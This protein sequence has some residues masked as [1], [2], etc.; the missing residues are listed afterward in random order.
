M[1]H[2]IKL[3]VLTW[4]ILLISTYSIAQKRN[5][6]Y[7]KDDGKEV[8][9]KDSADFMRIIQEPDSS[10]QYFRVLEFYPDNSRKL[11]GQVSAFEP[12]LVFEGS[13]MSFY[14]NGK[15]ASHITYIMGSPFGM[16]YH[17]YPDGKVKKAL[18]YTSIAMEPMLNVYQKDRYEVLDYFDSAGVQLVKNGNGY[19]VFNE[20]DTSREEGSYRNG[21]KDSVWKGFDKSGREYEEHY[22]NGDLVKGFQTMA[23]GSKLHYNK[24]YEP[25]SFI[26]GMT[27]F[28]RFLSR[29]FVYPKD[30]RAQGIQG[31]IFISVIVKA[32]GRLTFIGVTPSLSPSIDQAAYGL[33]KRSPKWIPAKLRGVA[34]NESYVIPVSLNLSDGFQSRGIPQFKR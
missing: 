31:K 18:N 13:A 32:D 33:V 3:P 22:K 7:F 12:R 16:A 21:L 9:M 20:T 19:A 30:A 11:I 10:S 6:Y 26:G 29:S 5:I 34:V 15:K 8:K 27:E 2:K 1:L 24:I 4:I 17:F 25:S 14:K 28:Y 23:N